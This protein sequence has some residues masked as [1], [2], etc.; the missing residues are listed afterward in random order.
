MQNN[1]LKIL[2]VAVII[3]V[4]SI[5]FFCSLMVLD[6]LQA[7][8]VEE[9]ILKILKVIGIFTVSSIIILLVT[10]GFG[11]NDKPKE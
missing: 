1:F 10:G 3:C 5:A 4:S 11:G 2:K 9:S 7:T 6:V 8:E